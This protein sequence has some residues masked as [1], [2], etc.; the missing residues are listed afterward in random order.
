MSRSSTSPTSTEF[1]RWGPKASTR[2]S[3]AAP[4]VTGQHCVSFQPKLNLL[5]CVSLQ[6][7]LGPEDQS[8]LGTLHRDGEEEEREGLSGC[9][10]RCFP[11]EMKMLPPLGGA[12]AD[13]SCCL[14]C[15]AVPEGHWHRQADG[16]H[17]GGN[18][19]QA[20]SLP[21][22]QT[23]SCLFVFVCLLA[24]VGVML[25]PTVLDL[26]HWQEKATHT[27]R[28]PWARSAI[29]PKHCRYELSDCNN[30]RIS[31]IINDDIN[32]LI[33]FIIDY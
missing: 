18:W 10:S 3:S 33:S 7:G 32:H 19:A 11:D 27:V 21:R 30:D 5:L 22:Y 15:S 25:T 26:I 23:S 29:S 2:G 6:D 31:L 14:C 13:W 12:Y 16:Q 28:S 4:L 20:V 24:F 17:C 1:T 8:R 9:S